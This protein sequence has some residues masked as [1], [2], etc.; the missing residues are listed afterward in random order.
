ML[1]DRGG[2]IVW[3]E[4]TTSARIAVSTEMR[5]P[6]STLR[7]VAA[8]PAEYFEKVMVSVSFTRPSCI[9]SNSRYRVIILVRDA[10]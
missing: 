2:G 3:Q 9:A 10:G 8:M 6:L 7:L 5:S 1:G 4:R